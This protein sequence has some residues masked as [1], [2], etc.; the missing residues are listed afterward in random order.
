MI[1]SRGELRQTV[2]K[3]FARFPLLITRL[4]TAMSVPRIFTS[5]MF[6]FTLLAGVTLYAAAPEGEPHFYKK[7]GDRELALY[8][9]RPAD[10][11]AGDTR[12][13]I[14]FFHGGGWTGGA[15]GQ[16]TWAARSAAAWCHNSG[17]A[18]LAV[19]GL[20]GVAEIE[21]RGDHSRVL[22]RHGGVQRRLL[23]HG[24][25]GKQRRAL[26]GL[27]RRRSAFQILRCERAATRQAIAG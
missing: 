18:P 2:A 10:W 12:P 11:Q 23:A 13:A 16:A 6:G 15:P 22:Q 14:V 1:E 20:R 27:L 3:A 17:V 7:V 24:L 25:D 5:I 9:T 4:P 21:Q 19:E 26:L 8:V